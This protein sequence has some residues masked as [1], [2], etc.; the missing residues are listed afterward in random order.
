[1]NCNDRDTRVFFQA[2]WLAFAHGAL[3]GSGFGAVFILALRH[4][5]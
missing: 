5:P 3:T 1:M 4:L 2:A